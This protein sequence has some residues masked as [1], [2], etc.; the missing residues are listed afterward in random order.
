MNDKTKKKLIGGVILGILSPIPAVDYCCC[1]WAILGGAI[2]A[3]LYI[4]KSPTP[5]AP[6][7]GAIIGAIAGAIGAAFIIA[8]PIARRIAASVTDL[9]IGPG[10]SWSATMGMTP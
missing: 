8:A 3:H 10:V 4:K 5:V 6:A 7:E 1:I 9:A 2:A